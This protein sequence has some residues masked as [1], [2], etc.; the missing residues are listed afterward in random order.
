[1]DPEEG[2]SVADVAKVE[3]TRQTIILVFSIAGTVA[4][5]YLVRKLQDPDVMS[6]YRMWTAL[7]VK[8]W[9]ER[10]ARRFDRLALHMANVYN[11]EKL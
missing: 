3:T 5:V 2:V 9:A 6:L 4:T 8:R 1:V 7:T 11:G 10:Q